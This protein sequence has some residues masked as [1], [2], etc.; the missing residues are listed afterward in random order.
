LLNSE[1][2]IGNKCRIVV[3]ILRRR[4]AP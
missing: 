2:F 4:S 1:L 3:P